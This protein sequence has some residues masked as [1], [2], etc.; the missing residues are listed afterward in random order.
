MQKTYRPSP[1]RPAVAS[2][3]SVPAWVFPISLAAL[4]VVVAGLFLARQLL[5]LSGP[6]LSTAPALTSS[7]NPASSAEP[8]PVGV[9]CVVDDSDSM[10]LPADPSR[11]LGPQL[12]PVY[13]SSAKRLCLS[14]IG[15]G[16]EVWVSLVSG[17][18]PAS[19]TWA[20]PAKGDS[21]PEYVNSKGACQLAAKELGA[22]FD[23]IQSPAGSDTDLVGALER[24]P[25]VGVR[26]SW[27]VF[28]ASDAQ[29]ANGSVNLEREKINA[30]TVDDLVRRSAPLGPLSVLD[31]AKVAFLLPSRGAGDRRFP[32]SVTALKLFWQSFLAK[33]GSGAVM[34][35]FNT[36]APEGVLGDGGGCK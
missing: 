18:S 6:G 31:G 4:V 29:L 36:S 33:F 16:R 3:P 35:S 13:L 25:T 7:A 11:G 12:D 21:L 32:N 17:K 1:G 24:I 10:M 26:R 28:F 9:A 22:F 23:G 14:Q 34:T 27:R 15:F 30:A 8:P 20:I 19:K 5:T 2:A